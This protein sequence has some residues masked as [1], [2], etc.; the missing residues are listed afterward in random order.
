M[1]RSEIKRIK[2]FLNDAQEGI[3]EGDETTTMQM[4]LTELSY[5]S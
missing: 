5:P 2:N 1:D 3:P 4:Q